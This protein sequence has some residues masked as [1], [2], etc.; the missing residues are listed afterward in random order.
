[1]SSVKEEVTKCLF[2][3]CHD[4]WSLYCLQFFSIYICIEDKRPKGKKKNHER[5]SAVSAHTTAPHTA[6]TFCQWGPSS[7]P[8]LHL[9]G[10]FTRQVLEK[11]LLGRLVGES[12]LL[13]SQRGEMHGDTHAW[14][15]EVMFYRHAG[16]SWGI[17][18]STAACSVYFSKRVLAG[19]TFP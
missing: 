12:G 7:T 4:Q 13:C 17:P 14:E 2:P 3:Y 11:M 9:Q 15:E 5:F 6:L 1:M 8:S 18:L 19:C 10:W 16:V